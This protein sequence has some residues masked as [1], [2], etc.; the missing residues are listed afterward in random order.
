[1]IKFIFLTINRRCIRE[2]DNKEFAVKIIDR[3]KAP[4]D[5]VSKFLPR[6]LDIIRA[7]D[8]PNIVK[9]KF[10]NPSS[11]TVVTMYR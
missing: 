6:E 3:D 10:T 2:I 1:M 4:A 11:Q 5:F 9:V 8:H 7:L